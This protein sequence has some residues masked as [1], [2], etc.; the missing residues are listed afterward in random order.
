MPSPPSVTRVRWRVLAMLFLLS[1]IT[2]MD[3]V[4]ISA[5]APAMMKELRLS[6]LQMGAV[7]SAFV[8]SY[9]LLEIPGGWMADHWGARGVLT[10]I[11][12]WWSF[13]TA[14]T[15]W[16]WNC[17]SLL[18]IRLLFGAGEAGAFPSCSS[19]VARWFPSTERARAQGVL[20]T[21]TR[22]GGAIAPAFVVL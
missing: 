9:G 3:R 10:R 14:A 6:T 17:A 21:G 13:F 2:Y 8:F 12:L 1:M 11:V 20:L 15:A 18:T 16:A 19:S 22:L 7:F 4:C 5:T